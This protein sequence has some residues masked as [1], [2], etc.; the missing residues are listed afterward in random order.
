MSTPYPFVFR[1]PNPSDRFRSALAGADAD[2]LVE[3]QDE[4]LSVADLPLLAGPAALQDGVDGRLDELLVDGD[5]QLHLADQVHLVLMPS[6][7][8][9]VSLLAADALDVADRQ[10]EHLHLAQR[11]LHGLQP[12]GL[13]DG[14]DVFHCGSSLPR[15]ISTAAPSAPAARAAL[16][17]RASSIFLRA[18][19]S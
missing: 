1:D 3:R 11:V 6:V 8:L 19:G 14:D 16:A 9:G 5:L 17:V 10:A 7:D 13:D 12:G 4:D 2:H 18:A 15:A